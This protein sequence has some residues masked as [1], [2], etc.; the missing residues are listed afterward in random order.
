M[1]K[2]T[3]EQCASFHDQGYLAPLAGL[4]SVDS[5]QC[6]RS[7]QEFLDL[8]SWPLD[9]GRQHNPHLYLRWIS[10]L[11][12]HPAVLDA[13]EDLLGPN[14]L[15]WRTVFFIKQGNDAGFV[16]WHQDARYWG[17]SSDEV[18]TAWIALTDSTIGNGCLRVVAGS[19]RWGSVPHE[20]RPEGKNALLRGQAAAVEISPHA[21]TYLELK[22]GQFSLHHVNILHGSEPNRSAFLRAGLAVRYIPTHVRHIG[23]RQSATLV[24]G[25]DRYGHFDAAPVAAYDYDPVALRAH[26]RSVRR[27]AFE[28]AREL[29]TPPTTWTKLSM[30]CRIGFQRRTW[31]FL[32]GRLSRPA[33]SR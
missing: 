9:R 10:D 4:S 19:H 15:I 24:R 23:G 27:Y 29:L 22:A 13:V 17:L 30:L 16:A 8:S 14:I 2:L 20:I 32:R 21:V 5:D 25:V 11:A 26:G 31:S 18:V 28:V 6:R 33:K 12:H 7:L 1:R 3:P